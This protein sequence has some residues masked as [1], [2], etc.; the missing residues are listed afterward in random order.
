MFRCNAGE[1]RVFAEGKIW[2]DYLDEL[3]V[4]ESDIRSAL[5]TPTFNPSSGEMEMAK[6]ERALYDEFLRGSLLA[7]RRVKLLPSTIAGMLEEN[8][9]DQPLEQSEELSDE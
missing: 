9:A 7:I 3:E 4:W 8:N 6:N 1:H 5:E 2:Q